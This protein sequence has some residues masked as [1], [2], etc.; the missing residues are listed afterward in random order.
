MMP[1]KTGLLLLISCFCLS[2]HLFAGDFK[3]KITETNGKDPV[4]GVTITLRWG[5][6]DLHAVSNLEGDFI[7][8]NCVPG[9]YTVI[10]TMVGYKVTERT[11]TIGQ[12]SST[13]NMAL[14]P[15]SKEMEDVLVRGAR[16]RESESGARKT[17]Q[18]AANILNIIPAKTIQLLPDITVANVLQRVSGVS[19]ERSSNGDAQYAIIRG[20][21]KRYNYTLVNGIKI[22]SPDF[23]NRYLPM[24][25][26]PAELLERLEVIK[27]LTPDMEPDAIGGAMNLQMKNAP[28]KLLFTASA[29]SGFNELFTGRSF[30]SFSRSSINSQ[31]PR[32]ARGT[33]YY[34]TGSDFPMANLE[35]KRRSFPVNELFNVTFGNR[36]LHNKALGLL[37]A[38]SYQHTYRGANSLFF[39]P[40][41]Q[42]DPEH[43]FNGNNPT[44]VNMQDRQYSSEQ[45]RAAAY[46]KADYRF[47]AAHNINLT[48]MLLQLDEFQYR[49]STDTVFAINS[50]GPG[51]RLTQHSFRSRAQYQSIF[52]ATLHGNDAIAKHLKADWTLS[53]SKATNKMPDWADF[54]T[55]FQVTTDAGGHVQTGT[56]T[57][58]PMTRIWSHNTD[59]DLSGYGNL[60]YENHL[61]GHTF[62]LTAGGMYRNKQRD[63][64]Y[65]TYQLQPT[66]AN[67]PFTGIATA[68]Y[69]F[70]Q[71]GEGKGQYPNSN[72]YTATE[73][74]S[75]IYGMIAL[76]ITKRLQA[77]AGVRQENT[78][79]DF[80]TVLPPTS[81]GVSGTVEYADVLPSVHLKYQL[82]DKQ[83]LR[84]SYFKSISRPGFYELLHYAPGDFY[85]ESGNIQ[86]KHTTADN[87]DLRYEIFPKGANQLLAGVFYKRLQNPI[88]YALEPQSATVSVLHPEN[89]GQAT[90]YGGELVY[91]RYIK[92]FGIN[93][94]YT[95]TNSSIT[96]SKAFYYRDPQ[97]NSLTTKQVNQTRPLQ[98]Q[99]AHIGNLSFIY[100]GTKTGLDAQ[101][102]FVYTGSRI[103]FVSP[104]YDL[105]YWQ[106]GLMQMDFSLEKKLAKHISIYAKINNLL[107]VPYTVEMHK[108]TNT[109]SQPDL[110][111]QTNAKRILVQRDY[112][113]R[114][115]LVGLNFKL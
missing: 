58:Q 90:N 44:F 101:L 109:L 19:V 60:S 112:Y 76:D 51:N 74:V 86:L 17:E 27:A 80:Q 61:G 79:F 115:Y 7:F 8:K 95:Y 4:P 89:F 37:L 107:N 26:F 38:A 49:T 59:Q 81:T 65:I 55:A 102:A 104:Y 29:A 40:N 30:T 100:K 3:G 42:P 97:T 110:P 52:N 22:P 91:T 78:H 20:M 15:E 70:Q 48:A 83:N 88:E 113:G 56:E 103:V 33:G 24:D 28:E 93:F 114:N 14:I 46:M 50:S 25:L 5:G 62:K 69:S 32:E 68:S 77:V 108:P 72:S 87:L 34:A 6:N 10:F 73:N 75:G 31:S 41:G 57:L 92:E 54:Y 21:D 11:V 111:D 1:S 98:N 67:Q 94:N 106:K 64:F 23:K 82:N 18:V 9:T 2:F 45:Q 53:Y 105:D 43:P 13:V 66:N 12:G 63:N 96:T 47:S 71:T 84:L 39:Q 35:E 16:N 85:D 36:F 99:S